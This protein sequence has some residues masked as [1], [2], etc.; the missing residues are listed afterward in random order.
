MI[1][2]ILGAIIGIACTASFVAFIVDMFKRESNRKLKE[3]LSIAEAK[4]E[5]FEKRCEIFSNMHKDDLLKVISLKL[6]LKQSTDAL[7]EQIEKMKDILDSLKTP[8]SYAAIK[9]D[10]SML[11]E[12]ELLKEVNA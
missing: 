6:Q 10:E 5:M 12:K 1:T 7:H 11:E 4:A 9:L 8:Q 2:N 3:K